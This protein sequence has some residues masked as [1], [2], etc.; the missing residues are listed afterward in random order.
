M[1]DDL[2][3]FDLNYACFESC[4]VMFRLFRVLTSEML[5]RRLPMFRLLL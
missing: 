2:D 4:P 3:R 5:G 1:L